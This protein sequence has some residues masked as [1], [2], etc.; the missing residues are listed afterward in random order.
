MLFQIEE[1]DGSLL[2]EPEGPGAAVG[3]DLAGPRASV[4]VAVGGNAEV[5]VSQDGSPDPE[6]ATLRDTAGAFEPAAV[7]AVL[8]ALRGRAERALARPVTHAVIA[9]AGPLDAA[10][11]AAI[12]E[13][14]AASGLVPTR[15]LA[16]GDATALGGDAAPAAEAVVRGAAIAAE[17]DAISLSRR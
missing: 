11:R 1:P 9:I 16:A 6:T 13:A 2:G 15:I 4:A 5:L 14:A 10:C 12:G 3:I 8:L 7:A 17:D